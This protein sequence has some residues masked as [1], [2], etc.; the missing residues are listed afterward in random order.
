MHLLIPFAAPLA[1][2]GRQ[3]LRSLRLPR[4][5]AAL[6]AMAEVHRD[7]G[8]D[9]WSLSAPHER[10]LARALGWR[11][12]DGCLP[13]A[14]WMAQRDGVDPG[15]AAFGLITPAHWHLGTEQLT[16]TDPDGLMLDE[17]GS[18]ALLEAVAG[19][20]TGEGFSL[21][22][23]APLRWYVAHPSLANL[24]T[25]SLDRVV[26][27]NVDRWLT[28]TAGLV[29][30]LQNEVQMLLHAHPLNAEREQRGLLPVNS[31]WLSGCGIAPPAAGEVPQVDERLRAHALAEDWAAWA[32]A[33]DAI[34]D[35]L[36][37]LAPERISLC[38][39]RR[40]VT[41]AARPRGVVQRLRAAWSQP[42]LAALLE[43]L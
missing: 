23:G 28:G 29:R 6:A 2:A 24:P 32:K 35:Q 40:A 11:A 5:A 14:A 39:E 38:G 30:R 42:D 20:F 31:F 17:R 19:L 3:A 10:A 13:L 9:E 21:H 33:F 41:W 1:E 18:R 16:M 15:A 7:G 22:Y 37:A 8:G 27:R 36:P 34:N 43:G 12:A 25:A 26:G 4:L